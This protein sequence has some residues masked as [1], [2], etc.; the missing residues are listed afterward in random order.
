MSA[1]AGRPGRAYKYPQLLLPLKAWVTHTGL[2]T[3]A[4]HRCQDREG[5]VP[6]AAS[7]PPDGNSPEDSGFSR[8]ICKRFCRV[9][10]WLAFKA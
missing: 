5:A 1:T 8:Q 3:I 9:R 10:A 6:N 2:G 7:G 4:S